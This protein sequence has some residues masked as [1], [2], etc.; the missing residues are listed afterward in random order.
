MA[1]LLVHVE[2]ETEETFVNQVLRAHLV[3]RGFERVDAR[4]LGN[5]RQRD[6]RGGIRGWNTVRKDI[7]RHLLQDAGCIA[8]TMV[9]YYALPQSGE[10]AWP[11]RARAKAL[12][13]PNLG[14]HVQAALLEDL[15]R[16]VDHRRFVPFVVLHEF[17][18]LLF[19]DCE[20]FAQSI[21]KRDV[22]ASF[23]A[24]RDR[25]ETPEHIDDSPTTVPS[26]RVEDLV[27]EY[28]KPLFGSVAASEIGLRRIRAE[29]PHFATWLTRL[30]AIAG[31]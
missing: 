23:Q 17:E 21:G 25:F 1:R 13:V 20:I 27:P 30:E 6:R 2:G 28:Q 26:K 4:L 14:A 18:G 22:A 12:P 7:L 24:I 16:E 15:S 31:S 19:S 9:D 8:T 29:R 5:A 11:G 3:A 10:K